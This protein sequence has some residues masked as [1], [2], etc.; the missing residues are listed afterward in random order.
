MLASCQ[1]AQEP[2]DTQLQRAMPIVS[3]QLQNIGAKMDSN[4]AIL[5]RLLLERQSHQVMDNNR[6]ATINDL[7]QD[8]QL[9]R[10]ACSVFASGHQVRPAFMPVMDDGP[11]NRQEHHQEVY[12]LSRDIQ[13]VTD[14]W[15]EW[16]VGLLPGIPS[17]MSLDEQY[18]TSWRK[19][20]R[21]KPSQLTSL[22]SLLLL[23][24]LTF[25]FCR[26]TVLFKTFGLC[27]AG[28]RCSD[29]VLEDVA[30]SVC[31]GGPGS[32]RVCL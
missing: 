8:V 13:S 19:N 15:R 24:L 32:D 26:T 11:S 17:V 30:V 16:S 20:A 7:S 27:V 23:D 21:G 31:A 1:I 9:L 28:G 4:Q 3:Q 12:T 14:L 6:F 22:N 10:Q 25:D 2:A 5:Q 29:C 18:G